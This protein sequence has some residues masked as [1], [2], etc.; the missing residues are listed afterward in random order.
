ML[1]RGI[2]LPSITLSFFL[3]GAITCGIFLAITS[4]DSDSYNKHV[5][6]KEVF[7]AEKTAEVIEGDFQMEISVGKSDYCIDK[8]KVN[9]FKGTQKLFGKKNTILIKKQDGK[10]ELGGIRCEERNL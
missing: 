8:D 6:K 2:T 10:I 4:I 1:K 7:L 3:V 5:L 9:F